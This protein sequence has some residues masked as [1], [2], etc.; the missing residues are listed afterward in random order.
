MIG[1]DRGTVGP[2][3]LNVIKI[4]SQRLI[5]V[6]STKT[7]VMPVDGMDAVPQ[8]RYRFRA[9]TL[10]FSTSLDPMTGML[11]LGERLAITLY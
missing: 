6:N 2:V 3:K 10:L 4:S 9:N 7:N 1:V 5:S 8:S 11:R